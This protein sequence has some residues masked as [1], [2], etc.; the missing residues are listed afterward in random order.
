MKPP[1]SGVNRRDLLRLRRTG[2]RVASPR[3]DTAADAVTPGFGSGT[4]L[5][6]ASRPAMGSYFEVRLGAATPG[7]VGLTE[8]AK[9]PLLIS[10]VFGVGFGSVLAG[11][12]SG[13]RVESHA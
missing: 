12:W 1:R 8:S 11:M 13:G 7:A 6:R 4:D 3:A 5:V 10:L 2:V 9:N